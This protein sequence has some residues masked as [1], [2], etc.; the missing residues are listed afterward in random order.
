MRRLAQTS[1]LGN[2]EMGPRG[3]VAPSRSSLVAKRQ[4]RSEASLFTRRTS[5][6][7]H[8]QPSRIVSARTLCPRSRPR[9]FGQPQP[10]NRPAT[11][12]DSQAP[13]KPFVNLCNP[14]LVNILLA[15]SRSRF[16]R[17]PMSRLGRAG[18]ARTGGRLVAI[19]RL[20]ICESD[21][22]DAQAMAERESG[23]VQRQARDGSPEIELITG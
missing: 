10:R 16:G 18:V 19:L 21:G 23:W 15:G 8:C 17:V 12:R 5:F 13:E 22:C 9:G 3:V 6:T 14:F 20:R 1:F 2:V 11:N 4:L 7:R